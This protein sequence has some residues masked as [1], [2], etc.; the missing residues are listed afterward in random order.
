MQ[1]QA[2]LSNTR[3]LQARLSVA[4]PNDTC[5]V[6]ALTPLFTAAPAGNA[7]GVRRVGCACGIQRRVAPSTSPLCRR[8]A[9]AR[10]RPC[11]P[12]RA[13]AIAVALA[14]CWVSWRS[15]WCRTSSHERTGGHRAPASRSCVCA[16]G[17][18]S[19]WCATANPSCSA[20]ALS[21]GLHPAGTARRPAARC[22]GRHSMP[23][24]CIHPCNAGRALRQA[25]PD[26]DQV[27]SNYTREAN[28]FLRGPV[29]LSSDAADSAL[30]WCAA[31]CCP[32]RRFPCACCS[33]RRDCTLILSPPRVASLAAP[34]AATITQTACCGRGA[35][36]PPPTGA[37]KP[38]GWR[39][40]EKRAC[41]AGAARR[42]FA[43]IRPALTSHARPCVFLRP[44]PAPL[45]ALLAAAP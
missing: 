37:R 41:A 1:S 4:K 29:L 18:L 32:L 7:L 2:A 26:A 6:V 17:Q 20:F 9:A 42:R 10:A 16:P 40:R 19:S 31:S 36:R 45:F 28:T 21:A 24:P 13:A 5:L 38:A 15:A 12:C 25:E 43:A 27:W 30:S 3:P 34:S 39:W 35:T 14:C 23:T 8:P 33:C 22:H 44:A 11:R